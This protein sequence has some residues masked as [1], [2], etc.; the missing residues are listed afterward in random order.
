MAEIAIKNPMFPGSSTINQLEKILTFTGKPTHED[1]LSIDCEYAEK[2][3]S[4]CG[5]IKQKSAK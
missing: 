2:F 4:Q 5:N 1:I 3:I